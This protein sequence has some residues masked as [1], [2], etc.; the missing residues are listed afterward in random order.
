[1]SKPATEIV[2]LAEDAE[3]ALRALARLTNRGAMP[4]PDLYDVLGTLKQILPPLEHALCHLPDRLIE[5]LEV[6]EVYQ[7]DG[8]DPRAAAGACGT[9]LDTSVHWLAQLRR[10]LDDAQEAISGQGYRTERPAAP[11]RDPLA[12]AAPSSPGQASPRPRPRPA[13]Q[14]HPV[15]QPIHR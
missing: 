9:H 1:M 15:Q 3:H 10:A 14:G 8:T 2:R 7:D 11:A 12:L 5:S 13:I 4:A 6:Y